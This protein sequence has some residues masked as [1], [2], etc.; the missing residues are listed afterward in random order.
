M[1]L[2]D[3]N[4]KGIGEANKRH[5]YVKSVQKMKATYKERTGY[6]HNM[7]NPEFMQQF[8]DKR[9]KETGNDMLLHR[10]DLSKQELNH[11][12]KNTVLIISEKFYIMKNLKKL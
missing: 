8:F 10:K 3:V 2:L 11:L 6:E 7:Q 4:Q 12:L 9:E 5:D 1:D